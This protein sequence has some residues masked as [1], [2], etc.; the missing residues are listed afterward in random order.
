MR[1]RIDAA[2]A[3]HGH[4]IRAVADE[5]RA[6]DAV[7]KQHTASL[8]AQKLLQDVA[9]AVQE[10]AH[11]HIATIVTRCLQ[12]IITHESWEL[13]VIFEQKRGKTEARL[14]FYRDGFYCDP[15]NGSPGGVLDVAAFGLRVAALLLSIPAK[16]RLLVLDEPM[17]M[18]SRNHGPRMRELIELL[19]R[20]L[21]IQFI[22]VTHDPNLVAGTV[23]SL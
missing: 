22:I 14:C 4:A 13:R 11:A 7:R 2:V 17:K 5:K 18:L 15:I 12:T 1:R 9:K 20:E 23:I 19:S 6:L 3:E 10:N 8:T 21:D 16:R